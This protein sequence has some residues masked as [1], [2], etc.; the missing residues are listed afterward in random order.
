MTNKKE[1][2]FCLVASVIMVAMMALISN[3]SF[4]FTP[5]NLTQAT[6]GIRALMLTMMDYKAIVYIGIPM[7]FLLYGLSK[8]LNLQL[9]DTFW[10]PATKSKDRD[11][12]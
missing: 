1:W 8:L 10:I 2:E 4:G 7:G 9:S 3:S 12:Q 5:E 11:E 6:P